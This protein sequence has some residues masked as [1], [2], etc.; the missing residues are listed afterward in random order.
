[1]PE[2]VSADG[3][4]SQIKVTGEMQ[5]VTIT[6]A[7]GYFFPED[8]AATFSVE[9]SGVTVTRVDRTQITV[10]GTPAADVTV[11]LA[12][13]RMNGDVNGD[14][15][16]NGKDVTTLMKHIVGMQLKT[17]DDTVADYN[18]DGKV[19]AMDVIAMMKKLVGK[20]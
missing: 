15:K 18:F 1:M 4:L 16:L 19:N 9:G 7:E 10:S 12:A 3:E 11:T 17:F 14:G 13:P 5:T 2:N 8:Y 6:A 20:K